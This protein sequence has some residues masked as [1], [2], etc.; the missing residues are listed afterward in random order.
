MGQSVDRRGVEQVVEGYKKYHEQ[1]DKAYFSVWQGKIL[2]FAHMDDNI[3]SGVELLE[4]NL[5]YI[6]TSCSNATYS[7]RVHKET[8]KDN[9]ISDKTPYYGSFNFIV[10]DPYGASQSGRGARGLDN[11][12]ELAAMRRELEELK[13]E[14][15]QGVGS[16]G[17]PVQDMIFRFMD[18]PLSG[19]LISGL[20]TVLANL[21]T[22]NS[23]NNNNMFNKR[24]QQQQQERNPPGLAGDTVQPTEEEVVK[25]LNDWHAIDPDAFKVIVKIL[26]LAKTNRQ[27]YN[28]A[29]MML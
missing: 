6:E 10:Y 4:E 17:D 14:R 27:K 1:S 11:Y 12:S 28:M 29:K 7:I 25:A 20:G 13:A 23:N 24:P 15:E 3:D 2:K 22:G 19:Q 26:H 5:N 18:H 16:T 21:L 9:M 8:D